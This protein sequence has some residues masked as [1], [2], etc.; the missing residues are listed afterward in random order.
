M[1]FN[2]RSR[3]NVANEEFAV[4]VE[5]SN[6]IARPIGQSL[7]L[8]SMSHGASTLWLLTVLVL[9]CGCGGGQ[10]TSS[11]TSNPASIAGN[12]QFSTTPAISGTPALTIAGS[13]SQSGSSVGGAVHVDGS[14][15]FDPLITVGLTG[16]LMGG[17]ISLPSTPV[18]GQVITINGAFTGYPNNTFSGTYSINGGCADGEQGNVT[19]I[20]V[21]GMGN[22]LNGTFTNSMGDTFD[23]TTDLGQNSTASSAGSFGL[24]GTAAFT[25]HCFSS[26]TITTGSF[27]SGSFVLGTSVALVIDTGNGTLTFLGT[28]NLPKNEIN[29]SYTVA[30]GTCDQTGTAV[31]VASGPWDY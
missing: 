1:T 25:T 26:G 16:T 8:D 4:K 5:S 13:I 20:S 31:L 24:R 14:K 7:A 11:S 19:G 12:W 10:G 30:G 29:G 15:C 17:N 27:P 2:P 9:L 21:P 3:K 23:V 22:T 28:A 6:A 18:H